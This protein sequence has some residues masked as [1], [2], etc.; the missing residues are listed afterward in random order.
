M[1]N[2]SQ[3]NIKKK[4]MKEISRTIKLQLT[5]AFNSFH[6]KR[7]ATE[8]AQPQQISLIFILCKS[9]GCSFMAIYLIFHSEEKKR[10]ENEYGTPTC[11]E[12]RKSTCTTLTKSSAIR[13]HLLNIAVEISPL[14]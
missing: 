2:G 8:C 10:A 9:S 6:N 14:Q 13:A 1:H 5:S 12:E 11:A 3:C 4:V 7:T